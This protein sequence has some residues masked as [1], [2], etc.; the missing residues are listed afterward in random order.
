VE[1]GIFVEEAKVV[2]NS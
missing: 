1:S 2:P